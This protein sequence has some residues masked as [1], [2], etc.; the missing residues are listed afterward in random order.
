VKKVTD[1][2]DR[3]DVLRANIDFHT[4]L[5]DTYDREQPHCRPENKALVSA[6]L[7]RLADRAGSQVLIDFGCG[8]GF[9]IHL[10]EPYFKSIIGVDI[11]PAMISK[12][13]VC[14]GKVKL[15][16]ANTESVPL[17]DNIANVV[18]ANTFLHHLYDIRP[19]VAEAYRLLKDGGV[20]YSEEDPNALFWESFKDL[21]VADEVK[22]SYSDVVSRELSAIL[23]THSE[24]EV[25]KGIDA[26]VVQMAEYQK[27]M[28]GGMHAEEV[29]AIFYEAG[30]SKVNIEYYWFLGQAK[31]MHESIDLSRNVEAYLRSI[32]PLSAHLFKY[33]KVEAWK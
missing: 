30:F 33:F 19:T 18:T 20:F 21:S 17:D 22:E 24:I 31:L 10:A 4:A 7:A 1:S 25:N 3:D 9:V 32:L 16:Q 23:E 12:V 6:H 8:T 26:K 15:F 28:R 27:M 13:D 29:K 14:S 5:A 11:T 2:T